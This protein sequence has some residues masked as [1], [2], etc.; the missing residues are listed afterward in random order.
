MNNVVSSDKLSYS[1]TINLNNLLSNE[2]LLRPPNLEEQ[3]KFVS[4]AQYD[5]DNLKELDGSKLLSQEKYGQ[6]SDNKF[7]Y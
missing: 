6:M 4:K 2:N 5:F 7:Q 1:Q 3:P